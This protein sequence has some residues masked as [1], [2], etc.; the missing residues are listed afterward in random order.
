[1]IVNSVQ[2]RVTEDPTTLRSHNVI[3]MLKN[4]T[5][6][7]MRI[8]QK[9]FCNTSA[10]SA[11]V[12]RNIAQRISPPT[13]TYDPS[14]GNIGRVPVSKLTPERQITLLKMFIRSF[15]KLPSNTLVKNRF[16]YT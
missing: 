10:I 15:L 6:D 3:F 9:F 1:M 12:L 16:I 11:K 5:V 4:D 13:G 7:M 14:H 2:C 8:R